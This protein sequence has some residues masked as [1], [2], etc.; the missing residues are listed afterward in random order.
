MLQTGH[1]PGQSETTPGHM[2]HQ[3]SVSGET[4]LPVAGLVA[5]GHPLVVIPQDGPITDQ[6]QNG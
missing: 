4:A 1:L 2:G 3:Y 5:P 6:Q